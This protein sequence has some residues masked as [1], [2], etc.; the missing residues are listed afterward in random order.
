M[1]A[2][3]PL[4]LAISLLGLASASEARAEDPTSFAKLP[5][6]RLSAP[7]AKRPGRV[8][9][10]AK[11]PGVFAVAAPPGMGGRYVTVLAD[12]GAAEAMKKG[13][14]RGPS[15][16]PTACLSEASALDMGIMVGG[17]SGE[18]EWPETIAPE[19]TVIPGG[20][21]GPRVGV[22]AVHSER[23]VEGKGAAYL[24]W[25]DAWVDP[26]TRG[27]KLITKSALPLKLVRSSAFGVRVYA[28][29]D[30]RPDGKRFV[31]FVVARPLKAA[32]AI[33][34]E[35]LTATHQDN[36]TAHS[37]CAFIRV[38]L[39]ADQGSNESV[40][41]TANVVL[42]SLEAEGEAGIKG[43]P[44]AEPTRAPKVPPVPDGREI[45]VREMNIEVGV[46]Q[47]ARDRD[48]VVSVSLGW[49]G[50]ERP[51]FVPAFFPE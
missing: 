33:H 31:Q 50:R 49:G 17:P 35:G 46:S 6:G 5:V 40:S 11:V 45:R 4:A 27:T 37:R 41:V 28:A 2:R 16:S 44:A 32:E 38:G 39:P 42:P 26:A 25:T 12:Q 8:G 1:K 51:R 34:V 30:E 18:A 47:T 15:A 13:L 23:L 21:H 9:G 29:R 36:A 3:A 19:A 14:G 20:R 43:A 24:E 10:G 48:P 7:P 22:V